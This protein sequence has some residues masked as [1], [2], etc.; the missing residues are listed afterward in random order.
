ML[1][2][3]LQRQ[4]FGRVSDLDAYVPKSDGRTFAVILGVFGQEQPGLA[5]QIWAQRENSLAAL[6]RLGYGLLPDTL[7]HGD[8]HGDHARFQQRRLTAI[9]DFDLVHLDARVADLA[10]AIAADCLEPPDYAAIDPAA[11]QA[12]VGAYQAES[13]LSEP[14]LRLIVPLIRAY[15]VWLC[16][17]N[18][19]R[20]LDGD[21]EK[22]TRS[23]TRATDQRFPNL[24]ARSAAIESAL[25]SAMEG[26]SKARS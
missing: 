26:G 6:A 3:Q 13:A 10:L 17:F 7:V 5:E 21:V 4:G 11:V 18:L 14:E 23:L 16:W 19:M 8:F 15:Y 25:K 2:S 24:D 22:A 12:F 1:P 20:W 9:L